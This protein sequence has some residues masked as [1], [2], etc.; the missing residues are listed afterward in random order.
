[1]LSNYF[2]K[3]GSAR[4]TEARSEFQWPAEAACDMNGYKFEGHS[5]AVTLLPAAA[6]KVRHIL[7]ES[8]LT[9]LA[10]GTPYV[11]KLLKVFA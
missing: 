9:E 4:I 5:W 1:M 8:S 6:E 2:G 3:S 11:R 7:K 10:E